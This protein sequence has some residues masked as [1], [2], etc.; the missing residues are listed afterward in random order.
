M[1]KWTTI[2]VALAVTALTT[3]TAFA[4]TPDDARNGRVSTNDR[5][6]PFQ[7]LKRLL[8]QRVIDEL[9][10]TQEQGQKLLPLID[11]TIQQKRA[12]FRE[13][14][15]IQAQLQAVVDKKPVDPAAI[16]LQLSRL[17]QLHKRHV[18][19]HVALIAQLKAVLS[20]EQ[21]ARLVLLIPKMRDRVHNFV[22]RFGGVDKFRFHN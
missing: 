3:A 5:P 16:Q 22:R 13:L 2:V 18:A 6:A 12:L 4:Q 21:Q 14:R 8:I 17:E 19:Q 20:V 11:K 15:Q 1:R 7:G 9:Q 10:L